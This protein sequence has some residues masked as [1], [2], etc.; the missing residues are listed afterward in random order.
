[1]PR[2]VERLRQFHT[3][4]EVHLRGEPDAARRRRT[5][6]HLEDRTAVA[7][8]IELRAVRRELRRRP[9]L[10]GAGD[11]LRAAPP[12]DVRDPPCRLTSDHHDEGNGP[13]IGRERDAADL[14]A[15]VRQ[16]T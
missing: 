11:P 4:I 12:V 9:Y 8:E 3:A 6:R 10:A 2:L 13:R 15:R 16:R 7:E 5:A 14:V 1:A